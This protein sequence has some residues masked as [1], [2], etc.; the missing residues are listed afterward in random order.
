MLCRKAK[1]DVRVIRARR[2]QTEKCFGETCKPVKGSRINLL[3]RKIQP[4]T[5]LQERRLGNP[6]NIRGC[7]VKMITGLDH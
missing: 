3:D 4:L 6:N 2:V 5:G 7:P 1:R